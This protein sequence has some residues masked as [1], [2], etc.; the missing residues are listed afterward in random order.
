[1]SVSI[2]DQIE[3]AKR[4]LN[5]RRRV[6]PRWIFEGKMTQK[7]MD[8]EIAAMEAIVATL[9]SLQPARTTQPAML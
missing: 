3:A 2:E 8:H 7:K 1:M 5:L 6:Y 4:E 9:E